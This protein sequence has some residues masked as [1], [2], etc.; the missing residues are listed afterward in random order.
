MSY[1]LDKKIKRKKILRIALVVVLLIFLFYFRAGVWRG[2][3]SATHFIFHPVLTLGKNIGNG[4]SNI[5]VVF[6]SKVALTKENEDLKSQILASEADRANYTSVVDENNQ[7]KDT[8]G[9]KAGNA[10][11]ILGSIL[12]KPNRSPYDTLVIDIGTN[13]GILIGQKV[14]ALGNIPIGKIGA[15]YSNS[16]EVT[17]YSSPGEKTDVVVP[18]GHSLTGEAG[19]VYMQLV[20]RGG[21]NFEM[22][23]PRDFVL[24]KGAEVVL[25]GI[26]SEVVGV[27]QT[28]LSDPRDSYQKA[29]LV[30]P[31][32]IFQLKSVE[33][34]K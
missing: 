25:P 21:G 4:F 5:G 12:S 26:S 32:N 15:V 33:I 8:L 28:I 2:L 16:A 7:M 6:S 9:R 20:G 24:T 30:S 27:V 18:L 10:N 22:I 3:S 29:L 11:L 31:V 13:Y 1:L 14:F 23:L 19:N 34:E 17:L